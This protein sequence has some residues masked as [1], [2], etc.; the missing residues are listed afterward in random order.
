MKKIVQQFMICQCLAL[1]LI[2]NAHADGGT[3]RHNRCG[4][5]GNN[6]AFVHVRQTSNGSILRPK[7]DRRCGGTAY[8]GTG[9]LQNANG[10]PRLATAD[11]WRAHNRNELKVFTDWSG[12]TPGYDPY[13][14]FLNK[15]QNEDM[16]YGRGVVNL[17]SDIDFIS[18]DENHVNN[19]I[20]AS[21]LTGYMLI[22]NHGISDFYTTYE[23]NVWKPENL[24]DSIITASKIVWRSTI[25]LTSNGVVG[26]GIFESQDSYNLNY[27]DSGIVLTFNFQPLTI[28]LE[29]G[30][31][32]F[33]IDTKAH[34]GYNSEG[35]DEF[36]Q[37]YNVEQLTNIEN[38]LIQKF[39]LNNF[40][41]YP[42]PTTSDLTI[43][44]TTLN[45]EKVLIEIYDHNGKRV[46]TLFNDNTYQGI[47]NQIKLDKE[48]LPSGRYQ[49]LVDIGDKKFVRGILIY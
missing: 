30:N 31:I 8:A 41:I 48:D 49:L 7:N 14:L 34:V 46:K 40:D 10:R 20:N 17:N 33:A 12:L 15:L 37:S 35:S 45:K 29:E 3:R 26:T 24:N 2:T 32:L 42:V 1:I 38:N 22:E 18:T 5:K 27:T 25:K 4:T 36:L 9:V 19:N 16:D 23:I 47:Q 21:S 43:D 39:G 11:A 28:Q 44:F 6:E 13:S